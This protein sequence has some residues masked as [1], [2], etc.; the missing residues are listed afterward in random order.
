MT[1]IRLRSIGEGGEAMNEFGTQQWA[2][3]RNRKRRERRRSSLS[4]SRTSKVGLNDSRKPAEAWS[5]LEWNNGKDILGLGTN[6]KAEMTKWN[7]ERQ[8]SQ[9]KNEE[10]EIRWILN[11]AVR[12]AGEFWGRWTWEEETK[13]TRCRTGSPTRK[14]RW[15][16]GSETLIGGRINT[17]IMVSAR[18]RTTSRDNME[19]DGV[20]FTWVD[21]SEY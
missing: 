20:N 15:G 11:C 8:E 3:R 1:S 12:W 7:T 19:Q 5:E 21:S 17:L 16:G 9:R 6:D 4:D 13:L 14:L 10:Y 18:F 2:R